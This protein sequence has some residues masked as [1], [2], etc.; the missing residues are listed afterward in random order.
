MKRIAVVSAIRACPS[1]QGI[2][3][4]AYGIF[5]FTSN[6]SAREWIVE[7]R[8]KLPELALIAKHFH[9]RL[10]EIMLPQGMGSIP[11]TDRELRLLE[12]FASGY[13]VKQIANLLKFSQTTIRNDL[14]F[15]SLK[16]SCAN[17]NQAATKA[18]LCG[19]I[20]TRNVNLSPNL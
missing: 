5:T 6:S 15:A 20:D 16:L 11:L 1:L 4:D 3:T 17:P 12:L 13:E 18:I 19:L 2:Q 7:K 14:R 9:G 10:V 8:L